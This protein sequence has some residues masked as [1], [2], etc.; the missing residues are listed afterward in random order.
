MLP[1]VSRQNTT[2]TFGVAAGGSSAARAGRV[3]NSE[4]PTANTRAL[5]RNQDRMALRIP[6][7]LSY[8]RMRGARTPPPFMTNERARSLPARG[9]GPRLAVDTMKDIRTPRR[10]H[11]SRS[12]PAG[13]AARLQGTARRRPDTA[14]PG[15]LA[16]RPGR[17]RPRRPRARPVPAGR[18][19]DRQRRGGRAGGEGATAVA[20]PGPPLAG[21]PLGS[22]LALGIQARPARGPALLA[23]ALGLGGL[24]AGRG[25]PALGGAPGRS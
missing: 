11:G 23:A 2:S 20:H 17:G 9:C 8:S 16:R 5:L 1:V 24:P 21:G 22:A 4:A 10:D 25:R 19:G 13:P 14:R 3:R 12:D 6:G 7:L 18:A 15:R